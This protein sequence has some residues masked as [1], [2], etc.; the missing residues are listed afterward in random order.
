VLKNVDE[1]GNYSSGGRLKSLTIFADPAT[2]NPIAFIT[3][4]KV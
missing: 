3:K 4:I 2:L 1:S